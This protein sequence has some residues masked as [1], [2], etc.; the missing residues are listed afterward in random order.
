MLIAFLVFVW[1]FVYGAFWKITNIEIVNAKHTDIEAL[2]T[3]IYN[4]S[5]K[6][7]FLIIPNNHILFLSKG[8]IERH[9]ISTY[10]S[11]EGVE[12][13]KTTDK[14]IVLTIKDRKAMGV[15]CDEK[16]YF[17]DD[18]G[19][20]F[21]AAFDYT[22]AIFTKWSVASSTPLNFYDKALCLDLCI[23]KT[24]VSFLSEN[25]IM[26]IVMANEDLQM[27]TEHGFYIKA[28]NNATTT[29]RNVALFRQEYKGDVKAL[30]YVDVRFWD[31]IFYK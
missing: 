15:W 31:K 27:F 30:E 10:P 23:D 8:Q 25:K 20:L 3:D 17:F 4:I 13:D 6:K 26:K 11:V 5:N 18:E 1:W 12:I 28:L 7:K 16:C 21:K 9:I 14:E 19:I 24:F 22:G 2:K 29:M